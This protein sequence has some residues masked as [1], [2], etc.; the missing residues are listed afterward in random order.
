MHKIK[1]VT[2]SWAARLILALGCMFQGV[3]VMAANERFISLRE[4]IMDSEFFVFNQP[5]YLY[6]IGLKKFMAIDRYSDNL[7]YLSLRMTADP[8]QAIVF[9]LSKE[10]SGE[11]APLTRII[12]NDSKLPKLLNSARYILQRGTSNDNR[13]VLSKNDN[14]NLPEQSVLI[15]TLVSGTRPAFRV[16]MGSYRC[17]SGGI[18]ASV[19]YQNCKDTQTPDEEYIDDLWLWIGMD[20]FEKTTYN[21]KRMPDYLQID[22][23]EISEHRNAYSNG[24]NRMRLDINEQKN[25]NPYYKKAAYYE[26]AVN[27]Q[28]IKR[29]KTGNANKNENINENRNEGKDNNKPKPQAGNRLKPQA[30]NRLKPQAGNRFKPQAGNRLKPQAEN[31]SKPQAGNRLKPQ[32]ENRKEAPSKNN[33]EPPSPTN[34]K[35]IL[36]KNIG[37]WSPYKKSNNRYVK[38]EEVNPVIVVSSTDK[39]FHPDMSYLDQGNYYKGIVPLKRGQ[40]I[41]RW[42]H[43]DYY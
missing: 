24:R 10:V 7:G 22:E 43:A 11:E 9:E 12:T 17:M 29:N 19:Y 5:G 8:K 23:N 21:M 41:L 16:L 3:P 13:V 15:D 35:S 2:V 40:H 30:E 4:K 20:D 14:K 28:S 26:N 25:N 39:Y 31:R 33:R 42:A 38:T 36:Y 34:K 6:N 32:A 1:K 27:K 18:S 37:R